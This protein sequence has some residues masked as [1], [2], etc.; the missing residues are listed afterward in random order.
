MQ[1]RSFSFQKIGAVVA[2]VVNHPDGQD[3]DEAK[4]EGHDKV[5]QD[6]SLHK[7]CPSVVCGEQGRRGYQE[8]NEDCLENGV[9]G[10]R[11]FAQMAGESDG[12]CHGDLIGDPCGE[13][14]EA[15][16]SDGFQPGFVSS[17][18]ERGDE[19]GDTK[20]DAEEVEAPE[21]GEKVWDFVLYE[22]LRRERRHVKG[23]GD[24]DA[25]LDDFVIEPRGVEAILNE[26]EG[27]KARY[28]YARYEEEGRSP[29]GVGEFAQT[30]QK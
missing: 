1:E 14:S 28:E 19:T 10:G 9:D 7:F 17:A 8:T 4:Q 13:E 22:S 18:I 24:I 21:G 2:E 6:V 3:T 11:N 15:H 30:G 25:N 26:G 27:S 16:E 12:K 5:L 23:R 20:G 29:G